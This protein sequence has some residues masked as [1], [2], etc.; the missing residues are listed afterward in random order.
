MVSGCSDAWDAVTR[1]DLPVRTS[2]VKEGQWNTDGRIRVIV[3][4]PGHTVRIVATGLT[5]LEATAQDDALLDLP[6]GTWNIRYYIDGKFWQKWDDV[7]ID[8]TPPDLDGLERVGDARDGRY[9]VGAQMRLA[10]G[11]NVTIVNLVTGEVVGDALPW[12]LVDLSDG[13]HPFGILVRDPA[14]NVAQAT[15]QVRVGTASLLPDGAYA[16]G[17]VARYAN[18][19]RLWDLS[20]SYLQPSQARVE[21]GGAFLGNGFGIE[22]ADPVVQ[23]W[24]AEVVQ[25]GMDTMQ[26]ARALFERMADRLEYDDARLDAQGLLRPA[27]V[28][29]DTEDA[30]G[31]D[32]DG[33]GLVD[34]GAGNG[35]AGG[36]C[37]DLAATYVSLLR[38]AGVPA[39]L[40][41][42]Y[43]AGNVNGFHAWVEFYGGAVAGQPAWIPVDVSSLDGPYTQSLLVQAFGIALPEYLMLRI[44]PE[45][46]EVAGWST[47]LSVKYSAPGSGPVP[48]VGFAKSVR[49]TRTDHATL[50]FDAQTLQ[51]AMAASSGACPS[52][53]GFYI[54]HV[55]RFAGRDLDYGIDVKKAPAGTQVNADVAYPVEASGLE[56][57]QFYPAGQR[58]TLDTLQAKA[59][60]E[61]RYSTAK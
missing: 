12:P 5:T 37:R 36:I 46:A 32:R 8:A 56:A 3:D 31:A 40:V 52:R 29:M 19:L 34:S 21:T 2:D 14:G 47:A 10:P 22:P 59:Q 7:R 42:G 23:E 48:D 11:E 25:P 58:F 26:I 9:V 44:V 27:D 45:A 61:I 13:L 6:D 30:G 17:V 43:V 35:V 50:C 1:P 53:F 55:V 51:R 28:L 16:F 38:A 15:V 33:N 20:A 57:Y 24:V 60:A 18:T 41:S 54:D 49:E 4:E 39:R